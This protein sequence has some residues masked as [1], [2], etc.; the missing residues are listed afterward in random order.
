MAAMKYRALINQR[1]ATVIQSEAWQSPPYIHMY[2][3][4]KPPLPPFSSKITRA[5]SVLVPI[6]RPFIVKLPPPLSL[7]S[8]SP[9]HH[10]SGFLVDRFNDIHDSIS[11]CYIRGFYHLVIDPLF[12]SFFFF[13][14]IFFYLELWDVFFSLK[15]RKLF[16]SIVFRWNVRILLN[17]EGIRCMY[18]YNRIF[19]FLSRNFSFSFTSFE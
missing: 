6:I 9:H 10:P 15:A 14:G 8:P 17:I 5:V 11:A 13:F 2:S 7:P 4:L 16:L 12:S 18:F 1:V 19:L 3:G